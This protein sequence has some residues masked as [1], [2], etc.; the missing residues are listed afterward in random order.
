MEIT[1]PVLKVT[2]TDA[3]CAYSLKAYIQHLHIVT[4]QK[5]VA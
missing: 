2:T 3:F 5:E 1:S 4:P